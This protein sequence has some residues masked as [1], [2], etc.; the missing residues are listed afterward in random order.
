MHSRYGT[1]TLHKIGEGRRDL[2]NAHSADYSTSTT[3]AFDSS[4]QRQPSHLLPDPAMFDFELCP[5]IDY[6]VWKAEM[7]IK[8]HIDGT[9]IGSREDQLKYVLYYIY[10]EYADEIR[11]VIDREEEKGEDEDWG[12]NHVFEMMDHLRAKLNMAD[13]KPKDDSRSIGEY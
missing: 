2:A 8:L 4:T 3:L 9:S 10:P 11:S 5:D 6:E 13:F 12:F 1:L 7:W